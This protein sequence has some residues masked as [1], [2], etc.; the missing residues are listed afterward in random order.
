M[1]IFGGVSQQLTKGATLKKKNW[2]TVEKLKTIFP[3]PK[4]DLIHL[5]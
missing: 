2:E 4:V 5:P 3:P 1:L